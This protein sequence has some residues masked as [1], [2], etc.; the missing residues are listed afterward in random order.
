M[1]RPG[2]LV[3]AEHEARDEAERHGWDEDYLPDRDEPHPGLPPAVEDDL[4][5]MIRAR[6]AYRDEYRR[7]TGR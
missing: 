7:R 3:H 5:Q 1:T 2:Y 4:M 6:A